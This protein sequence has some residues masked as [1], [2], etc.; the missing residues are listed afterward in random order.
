MITATPVALFPETSTMAGLVK[1]WDVIATD[2]GDT[3]LVIPTGMYIDGTTPLVP[4]LTPMNA[5]AGASQW[6]IDEIEAGVSVTIAK[7]PEPGSGAEQV[8]LRL[9]LM[10]PP[11]RWQ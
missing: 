9:T 4:I 8:Q 11:D 7:H 6:W 2:D 10:A 3:A 5:A 1:S